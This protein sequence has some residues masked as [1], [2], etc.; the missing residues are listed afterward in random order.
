MYIMHNPHAMAAVTV[1][2][3]HRWLAI[4]SQ[5][6]RDSTW[7]ATL[8]QWPAMARWPAMAKPYSKSQIKWPRTTL[9][10]YLGKVG[11]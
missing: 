9:P 5:S 11:P 2:P 3:T 1:Q 4:K 8:C 6:D 7:Y 10:R